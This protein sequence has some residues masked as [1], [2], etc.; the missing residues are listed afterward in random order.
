MAQT[1]KGMRDHICHW[2]KRWGGFI[3]IHDSVGIFN[4]GTR[5]FQRNTNPFRLTGVA[6]ILGIWKEKP[7]AIEVKMGK[8][9]M[10]NP[11][12]DF[13]VSW[14]AHGGIFILAY[15]LNDVRVGLKLPDT[16]EMPNYPN[17]NI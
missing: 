1:E 13:A 12:A 6:D 3:F 15:N 10:S 8:N 11:Q 9:K 14:V 17:V 5:G 7:L 2:V 4:P 16:V